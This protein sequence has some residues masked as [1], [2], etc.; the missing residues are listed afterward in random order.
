MLGYSFYILLDE[1]GS[2]FTSKLEKLFH[3]CMLM[4]RKSCNKEK[5]SY[6]MQLNIAV[7]NKCFN[8]IFTDVLVRILSY[9]LLL[10]LSFII[11]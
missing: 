3:S 7:E 8:Y 4:F 9:T 6:R 2:L 1:S 5:A 10:S 11:Q